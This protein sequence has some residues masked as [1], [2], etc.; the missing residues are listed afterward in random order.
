[1]DNIKASLEAH[2][3]AFRSR[4]P[5]V[6][7]SVVGNFLYGSQNYGLST[8]KSDVDSILIYRGAAIRRLSHSSIRVGAED[9]KLYNVEQFC[10]KLEGLFLPAL[11]V[12][13]T[14]YRSF[15]DEDMISVFDSFPVDVLCRV[16]QELLLHNLL[17]KLSEHTREINHL[18]FLGNPRDGLLYNKKRL[19][20]AMR[21]YGQILRIQEGE[22]FSE[23]LIPRDRELLLDIK[24]GVEIPLRDVVAFRNTAFRKIGELCGQA[25]GLPEECSEIIKEFKKTLIKGE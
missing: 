25:P 4:F 20:W 19:Y 16:G 15:E 5:G 1:M 11:E 10:R 8:E 12:F 14:E 2:T 3:D 17:L 23:T 7:T 13:C 6:A 21:V 22:S 18:A 9:I 24:N